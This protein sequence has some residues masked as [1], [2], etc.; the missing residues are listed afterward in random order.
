VR[1]VLVGRD[2]AVSVLLLADGGWQRVF[3]GEVEDVF[4][5][6][7][8]SGAQWRVGS[9]PPNELA[10]GMRARQAATRGRL[11][12]YDESLWKWLSTAR[13]RTSRWVSPTSKS[14][15]ATGMINRFRGVHHERVVVVQGHVSVPVTS[16]W[17]SRYL[18]STAGLR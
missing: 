15:G 18:T 2:S 10:A 8:G 9:A 6:R 3:H 13:C 5:R 4:V 11:L 7:R 16:N 12:W 14:R 1:T 17:T